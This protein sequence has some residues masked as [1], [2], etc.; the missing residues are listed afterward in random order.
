ML[1]ILE[2]A[3]KVYKQMHY[4]NVELQNLLTERK[5]RKQKVEKCK[6]SASLTIGFRKAHV[7]QNFENHKVKPT[8]L[9]DYY[10]PQVSLVI[11]PNC[12]NSCQQSVD[13]KSIYC[14]FWK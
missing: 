1:V 3:K 14:S 13:R 2:Q 5:P 11:I 7:P 10:V 6:I 8:G 12:R 9:C 4:S